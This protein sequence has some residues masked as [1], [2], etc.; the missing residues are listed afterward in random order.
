MENYGTN[1]NASKKAVEEKRITSSVTSNV[2]VKKP[3]KTSELAKKFFA[4]DIKTTASTVTNDVI[5]PGTKALIVNILKKAVDFLFNGT[6]S[7]PNNGYT[8]YSFF[9]GAPRNV[10][11]SSTSYSTPKPQ[12]PPVKNTI[13]AIDDVIFQERGDAELVLQ[14]MSDAIARYGMVSVNDFYDAIG[15]KAN[16][17][18]NR[19]G[20]RDLSAAQVVRDND[21]YK[22][23]FPKVQPLE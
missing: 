16:F 6:Y 14:V 5:I 7:A 13:Y 9:G 12:Q 18:D 2:T 15:Q 20:W 11:Y 8:N 19:Y 21:G 4:Q 10:T 22:I 3:S 23:K 1:S 17:T